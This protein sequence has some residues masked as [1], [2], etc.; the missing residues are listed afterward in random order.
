M[1]GKTGFEVSELSL[2]TAELGSD[3]GIAAAGERLRPDETEAAKLLHFALDMGINLIDTAHDYGD[4]ECIIARALKGRRSEYFLVSKVRPAPQHPQEVRRQVE[5]SLRSLQTECID[6]MLL[7]CGANE[8]TP[9]GVSAGELEQL[10]QAGKVRFI[11]SSVYGPVAAMAAIECG[12]FDC[13][14]IAYSVLDRRVETSVLDRASVNN[15]GIIARSVLLKGALTE[16]Y[17]LLDAHL[18]PLKNCVVQLAEIAGS[19]D[20]LP[21]FAYRYVLSRQPPHCVLVGTASREEL[22]ACVAYAASGPLSEA[23]IR[24]VQVVRLK[25]EHWFNPGTWPSADWPSET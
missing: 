11:G 21:S 5:D 6:L 4:S 3:Y 14:Q 22:R 20:A 25:D 10:R 8:V 15:I 16:R 19:L 9:D 12:W 23:E 7:H 17:K 2:G 24:A 18:A 1:L 13:V